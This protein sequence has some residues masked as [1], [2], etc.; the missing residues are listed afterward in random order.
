MMKCFV[1]VL[2]LTCF[3]A[4]AGAAE[5]N[6]AEVKLRETLRNTMLQ[7]R[8]LQGEKDTLQALKDQADLEKKDLEGKL[9]KKTKEGDAALAEANK[10]L[11]DVRAKLEAQQAEGER[12]SVSLEKWKV[13]HQQVTELAAKRE[14][15]RVKLNSEKIELERKVADQLRKNQQMYKIGTEV[16][17]RYENFGLGTALTAREPFVGITKV[18][19]QNLVQDYGDKLADQRIKPDA[20]PAPAPPAQ[21]TPAPGNRAQA[22]RAAATPA[23]TH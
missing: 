19:L 3:C 5:Q 7:L 17:S 9:E 12:L 13:S 15:A 10:A 1:S 20:K 22:S 4:A 11:A 2:L 18:K 14:A 6:P 21:A 16:L 8:T 23:A